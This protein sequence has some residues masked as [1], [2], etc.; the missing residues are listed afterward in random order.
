M[1]SGLDMDHHKMPGHKI[2]G[3]MKCEEEARCQR[4]ERVV[5]FDRNLLA[6]LSWRHLARF[7]AYHCQRIKSCL[8]RNSA[9]LKT[10]VA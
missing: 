4:L 6:F 8:R 5:Y 9:K 10:Q 2:K 1:L 3:D 7:P